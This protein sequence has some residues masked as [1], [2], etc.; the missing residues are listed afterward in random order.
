M[1]VLITMRPVGTEHTMGLL[2]LVHHIFKVCGYDGMKTAVEIGC[3]RE[4]VQ[5]FL[6]SIF[7]A[8][9]LLTHIFPIM[10]SLMALVT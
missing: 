7:R 1:S 3:Y 5:R 6:Q 4:K 10:T 9:L 8:L 2:L